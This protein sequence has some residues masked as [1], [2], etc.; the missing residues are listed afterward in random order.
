MNDKLD[1]MQNSPNP[2]SNSTAFEFEVIEKGV[3]TIYIIDMLGNKVGVIYEGYIEPGR[4][5]INYSSDNLLPGVYFI[6]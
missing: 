6:F 3:N 4:Y 1:L 5:S 2:F